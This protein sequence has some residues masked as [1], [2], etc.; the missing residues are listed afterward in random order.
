MIQQLGQ[1]MVYVDNQEAAKTF[2]TVK[3]GFIFD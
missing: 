3:V 1:V 2:W